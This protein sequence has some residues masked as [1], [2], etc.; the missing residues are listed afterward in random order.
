M[1]DWSF[2]VPPGISVTLRARS[3]PALLARCLGDETAPAANRT[4]LLDFTAAGDGPGAPARGRY[5]GIPWRC[6][7]DARPEGSCTLAFRS[8]LLRE[9]LALHIALLPALRRLLLERNVALVLG[10]AFA[11][12]EAATVL[13]GETGSGKTAALLAALASGAQVIGDEFVGIAATGEVAPVLRVLALRR[14]TLAA[15][16]RLR[17]SPARRRQLR[18][19]ALAATLSGGRL[20]P[21]V[22]VSPTE[23]GVSVAGHAARLSTLIWLERADVPAPRREPID[24][25]QVIDAIARAQAGHDGAYAVPGTLGMGEKDVSRWRETLAR[26]LR[27]VQCLRVALPPGSIATDALR[28]LVTPPPEAIAR[29]SP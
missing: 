19:A 1:S 15:A 24:A 25:A 3:K 17:P 20:D 13:S 4:L 7:V 9:Y 18:A 8:P 22:H 14:A 23:L 29:P 12:A 6:R 28:D 27:D 26:A 10:A 5:K 21:L 16:P 2:L 11:S